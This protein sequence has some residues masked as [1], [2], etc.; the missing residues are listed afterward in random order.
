MQN[1]SPFS[2]CLKERRFDLKEKSKIKNG[3]GTGRKKCEYF[4]I[5]LDGEAISDD[6][7][8]QTSLW[9]GYKV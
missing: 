4:L 8:T 7:D 2:L 3:F 1:L 5:S 6:Q 9:Y